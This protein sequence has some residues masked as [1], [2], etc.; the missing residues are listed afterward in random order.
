MPELLAADMTEEE[1]LQDYSYIEKA[2]IQACL[3]I[4]LP[5]TA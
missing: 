3:R 5:I 4:V 2:D 1:I